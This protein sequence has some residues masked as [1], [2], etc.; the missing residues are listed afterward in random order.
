MGKKNK[1]K[2]I[3]DLQ[4]VAPKKLRM[5]SSNQRIG[6]VDKR[7]GGSRMYVRT[8]QGETLL[9]RVPGRMKKYLWIREGDIVLIELWQF[10]K[11]KAEL[12]YKYRPAEVKTLKSSG[13][14]TDLESIE[15]F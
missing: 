6:I 8:T 11:K 7:L 12:V 13:K 2:K 3:A 14:L 9:A 15:E 1:K 4:N 10:D 5:P